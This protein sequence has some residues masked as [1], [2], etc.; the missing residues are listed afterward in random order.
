[1]LFKEF[2]EYLKGLEVT[3]ERLRMIS[4]LAKLFKELSP[5]ELQKA[6]Y[7]LLGELWPDWTGYPELGVAEKM[8]LEALSRASGIPKSELE[9]MFKRLGD[10]GRVAELAMQK[11]RL[12]ALVAQQLT[13]TDVYDSLAKA[14]RATGPG[15]QDL[16]IRILTGLFLSASPI[17]AKYIAR[18]VLGTMRLG[19]QEMT[20]LDGLAQAF[21]GTK[22]KRPIIESAFNK[23]PDIGFIARITA[24]KG[25]DGLKQIRA[26]PGVPIRPMLAERLSSPSEILMKIGGEGIAE[27]KYD[28][29]RAQIH[30]TENEKIII[31]SRR[32]ENITN[33]Y[34]DVVKAIK[35]AVQGETFIVEGEIVCVD[36]DT[37][38]LRPFQELMHRKRKYDIARAMQ[39]YP[40]KVFL[41]DCLYLNGEELLEKP[42]PKRREILES[43]VKTTDMV[44]LAKAKFVKNSDELEEFMLKA[45]EDGCEGVVVKSLSNDAIYEAGARGWKWIKYKRDYKSEM[46]DT[47]DLVV[48]GAFHG[49]GRRSGTYGALLVATYNPQRDMFESVCKVGSGFTDTQ[50]AELPNFLGPYIV[51]EKPHNVDVA[52]GMEPDV[53]VYPK[54][55]MEVLGAE[56]T[57]S[58]IHTCGK[59][60]VYEKFKKKAGLAIRFPRFI[61]W[62]PDKGPTDATTSQEIFEMY[63]KQLR[64]VQA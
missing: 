23:Y 30:K 35:E 2:C 42:Y 5:E 14:A 44:E 52:E 9:K 25:E 12:A 47:V 31:Y 15:S 3:S 26:K 58:P 33:Q 53:W 8:C 56:I 41:F 59:D 37:G 62:R 4:I 29:E 6:T 43:I 57:L 11:K 22:E 51:K 10:I 36:P 20:I 34:P 28:G 40:V 39:E 55:V 21:F 32:L 17:E 13:I 27:Y 49:R 50:L 19:I 61:N 24:E 64:K 16:K 63:L 1:M 48:V 38:E 18:I 7:L 46:M 45:V 54:L 60:I